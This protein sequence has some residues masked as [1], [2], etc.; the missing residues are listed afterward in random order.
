MPGDGNHQKVVLFARSLAIIV[1]SFVALSFA[2]MPFRPAILSFYAA[3]IAWLGA[4]NVAIAWECTGLDETILAV[5]AILAWRRNRCTYA[6]AALSAL[7]IQIYNV[8]RITILSAYPNPLLHEILF[9]LGG[10]IV[11][12]GAVY[13]VMKWCQRISTG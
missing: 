6:G 3:L 2:L 4:G 1:V 9:R 10:Y 5:V 12:L 13:A 8:L 11:I 7:A